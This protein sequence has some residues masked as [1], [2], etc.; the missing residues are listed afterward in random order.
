MSWTKAAV[1]FGWLGC[2]PGG[3]RALFGMIEE[4]KE[5]YSHSID[6]KCESKGVVVV[7]V[8][9]WLFHVLKAANPLAFV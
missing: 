7:L 2:K 9:G 5:G 8:R 4:E 3:N 6:A 1:S